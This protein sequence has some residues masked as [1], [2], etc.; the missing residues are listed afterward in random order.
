MNKPRGRPFQS[1]NQFG[2]GRPKGR[3]NR[4][5]PGDDLLDKFEPYLMGECIRRALKEG[6]RTALRLYVERVSPTRRGWRCR[7]G[8][9]R[10]ARRRK[11][12]AR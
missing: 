12:N 7:S 9:P 1:G 3:R 10:S 2:R 8:C 6:D 11:L 4:P 5:K